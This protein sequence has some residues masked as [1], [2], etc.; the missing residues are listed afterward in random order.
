MPI[1]QKFLPAREIEKDLLEQN[2]ESTVIR[3]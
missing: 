1:L 2:L 3:E